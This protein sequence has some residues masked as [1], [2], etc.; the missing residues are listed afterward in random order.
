MHSFNRINSCRSIPTCEED[1]SITYYE[2]W[3]QSYQFMQINP[4]R[5]RRINMGLW[6]NMF[7]SYQFMQINPDV[8]ITWFKRVLKKSFQS[9]QFMQINPDNEYLESEKIQVLQSFNRINSCRS[10]PTLFIYVFTIH[11]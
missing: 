9:Y 4:D 11:R 2:T 1:I 7:Q 5:I 10:I 6:N 3:F 8:G